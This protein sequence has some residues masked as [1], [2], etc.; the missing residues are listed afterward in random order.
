MSKTVVSTVSVAGFVPYPGS[1]LKP[2]EA[3]I[4][5]PILLDL[6]RAGKS[7]RRDILEAARTSTVPAFRARFEWD[8]AQAAEA[9]RLEQAGLLM[10]SICVKTIEA[11]QEHVRRLFAF[12]RVEGDTEEGVEATERYM[13]MTTLAKWP[14]AWESALN[15][16]RAYLASAKSKAE[17]F[18]E[19]QDLLPSLALAID[20]TF[21][22]ASKTVKSNKKKKES[23]HGRKKQG[24]V[25]RRA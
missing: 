23:S 3:T 13:A 20:G 24:A 18:K 17:Q 11:G 15:E 14:D 22:I 1:H 19:L 7:T 25:K 5:G 21:R 16:V 12:V 8:D 10:R 6:E 4:L 2:R 9:H